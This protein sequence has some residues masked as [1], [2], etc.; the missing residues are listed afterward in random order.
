MDG[1]SR[2]QRNHQDCT[3]MSWLNTSSFASL[4]K[5]ALR[6]AQKTIDKALDIKEDAVQTPSSPEEGETHK[7]IGKLFVRVLDEHGLDRR[8]RSGTASCRAGHRQRAGHREHNGSRRR[9]VGLVHRLV[10]RTAAGHQH[11]GGCRSRG[12]HSGAR[13]TSGTSLIIKQ[14][15]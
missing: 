10:L 12:R 2:P 8:R 13:R 7:P 14:H 11:D 3:A 1:G 4:A 6:E 9:P 5:T 15:L